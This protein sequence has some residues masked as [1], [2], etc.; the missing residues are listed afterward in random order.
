MADNPPA[1]AA[2][3]P[4]LFDAISKGD[5]ERV[6]ALLD[7]AP[8]LVN[9]RHE[10]G[11]TPLDR[12]AW[13]GKKESIGRMVSL[14]MDRGAH[15]GIHAAAAL[16][17]GDRVDALL[18]EDPARREEA[19]PD[20]WLAIHAAAFHGALDAACAL[21]AHGADVNARSKND[22]AS[23]ALHA[24]VSRAHAELAALLLE[25]RADPNLANGSGNT[26][27]HEALGARES[28]EAAEACFRLLLAAGANAA[29]VNHNGHT[30][31][32]NAVWAGDR[33]AEA[34]LRERGAPLF[35]ARPAW[36]APGEIVALVE[37]IL[38]RSWN[39]PVTLGDC[40]QLRGDRVLR[41]DVAAA[42]DVDGH[43]GRPEQPPARVVV[44]RAHR[45]PQRPYDPEAT[46][47]WNPAWGLFS[48]WAG[49]Q[50]FASLPHSHEYA[51]R[52]FGGDREAGVIVIEDL[53]DGE[54]LVD[55]LMGDDPERAEE[56]LRMLAECL[57]KMHAETMGHQQRYQEYRDALGPRVRAR[58][59]RDLGDHRE[60]LLRGF[61]TID[62]QPAPGFEAEFERLAAAIADPGPF[63]AYVHGD[64][65]P[66]NCR[67][68]DGKLRLFDFETGG[69]R[70]AL[71]DAVYGRIVFPSC[72]CVN[73]LPAHV[74][75]MM[76]A[77]Y[78]AQLV[79]ACPAA[80]D[81]DCFHRELVHACAA[82]LILNGIWLLDNAHGDDWRWGISTWRQ[83]VLVRLDALADAT[84]QF[85][86]LPAMGATARRC[87]QRLRE[88][89]PPE[90][91]AM[92]LY[93]AFRPVANG[94]R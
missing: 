64:P 50:L 4:Q 54:A 42:P 2:D 65:C 79:P 59:W 30:P 47:E 48:D 72:W 78:R 27:V 56:G 73:R 19:G 52:L 75:P 68:V 33:R 66:D 94:S 41:F 82:W 90:A 35:A 83:R 44:K 46:E 3:L 9:A 80:A 53:G 24:A 16:N 23:Y 25:H 43:D 58:F 86:H 91:D 71:L 85:D 89:W 67:I 69:F 57:G 40:Y 6:A 37:R 70:H 88:I 93:P 1:P 92:P 28:P 31:R 38:T 36:S 45:H 10:R 18:R 22:D 20:G 29:V 14:L 39:G 34:L 55:R 62:V 49:T 5:L 81:D 32:R 8:A 77:A 51:L 13:W 11:F 87:A 12:A 74:V 63:L 76:E 60:R 7:E 61:R 15:A 26:P 17:M 84:E 21:I